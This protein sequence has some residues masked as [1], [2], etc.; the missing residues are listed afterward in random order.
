[1]TTPTRLYTRILVPI[2]GSSAAEFALRFARDLASK[3][4]AELILLHLSTVD[5]P[6]DDSPQSHAE[7]RRTY[8]DRLR[9]E[10][11]T[12][13][14]T[15][16]IETLVSHNLREALFKFIDAERVSAV[17][18]STRGRTSML[19]WLFGSAI[20]STLD[21]FP[22]PLM[23]VRPVYQ[24]IV[25]PLDGSKW[26]ESAIPRAVEIARLHDAE[27][28]LVHVHQPKGGDYAAEWALAG[29]QQIAD[30]GIEQMREQLVALRNLLRQEGLRAREVLIQSG[31]PAQAICDFVDSE[32]GIIL[33]VM[34][35]HGR[36]GLS[37]WLMGS[38]AQNVI[39]N[40]RSPVV[41]V[42]IDQ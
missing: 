10:I 5:P 22:V 23:L 15:L 41:L 13:G 7:D 31:N 35:T 8:L 30:Q 28:V 6:P 14:V 42:H 11:Y 24:K 33:I 34:S 1:M 4:Q 32:D 26:S 16:R 37:R 40:S 38:V 17:V 18:L 20:E 9:R 36:T 3:H 27:L 29:Q 25:V 39:K 19:R 12:E 21:E 2:D